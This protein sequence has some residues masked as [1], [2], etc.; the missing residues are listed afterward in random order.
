MKVGVLGT[1]NMGR[2]RIEALRQLGLTGF[3]EVLIHD[4][5]WQR[6]WYSA[7]SPEILAFGSVAD[8][9]AR[10]PD[11]VMI[12]TPPDSHL[13]LARQAREAGVKG[14]FVEKPLALARPTAEEL[15]S[16]AD[17]ITM[18]GCQWRFAP[19]E[20]LATRELHAGTLGQINQAVWRVQYHLPTVRPD[21]LTSYVAETGALLDAGWHA[22]DLACSWFGP[23]DLLE[24]QLE[25][26][27]IIGLPQMD[28]WAFLNVR[29]Q[30][31]T[32][33]SLTV[34]LTE[35]RYRFGWRLF[36]P[37]G[38]LMHEYA[39]PPGPRVYTDELAHF[40]ACVREGQP[41]CNSFEQAAGVL[42]VLLEAR[43]KWL[44]R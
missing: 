6:Q 30:N 10:Q 38:Q 16:F 35:R 22:L 31:G 14:I 2:R 13:S 12:C 25:G 28:A 9:L 21:Y 36:G 26:G 18:A 23:A 41:T 5:D 7:V 32:E 3:G 39:E 44:G 15:A 1:G 19:W 37:A 42:R 40:L 33:S 20:K 29:H 27:N 11:A 24:C 4:A 43:A 17:C 8:L 34:E